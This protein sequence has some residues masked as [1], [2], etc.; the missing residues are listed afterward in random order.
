MVETFLRDALWAG[1]PVL[2]C[3][4]NT[5]AS[6]VTA[7]LLSAIRI[8]ELITTDFSQYKDKALELAS[9]PI[10]LHSIKERIKHNRMTTPLFNTKQFTSHIEQAYIQMYKIYMDDKPINNIII[11]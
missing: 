1:L 11:N 10:K 2:T 4:G 3:I 6:R 7:S 8:P 5:F 9:N